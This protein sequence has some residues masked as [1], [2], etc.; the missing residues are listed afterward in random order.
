MALTTGDY[1]TLRFW[2]VDASGYDG[3]VGDVARLWCDEVE[4]LGIGG[5]YDNQ[6]AIVIPDEGQG[7]LAAAQ[8][9]CQTLEEKHLEVTS[10]SAF[11][12]TF[13]QCI[14]EPAEDTTAA[15]RERD[16]IGENTWAF[17]LTTIF[18]PENQNALDY[19]MAGNTTEYEGG[20]PTVPEGAWE[21]YRCGYMTLEDDGWHGELVGTG[22]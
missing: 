10:G 14:T 1:D 3:P 20:D 8:E 2:A 7:Y 9:F 18:V 11:K 19:S 13:V 15:M 22:W 21:Y 6:G 17:T 12:Y 4:F 16:E 5:G